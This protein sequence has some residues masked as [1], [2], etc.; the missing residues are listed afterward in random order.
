[1]PDYTAKYQ[2]PSPKPNES[3]DGPRGFQGLAQRVEDV[4]FTQFGK[5]NYGASAEIGFT[6]GSTASDPLLANLTGVRSGDWN[7]TGK[8]TAGTGVTA[9]VGDIIASAG[10]VVAGTTA[11]SVRWFRALATISGIAYE[12]RYQLSSLGDA[13][14]VAIKASTATNNF[15]VEQDGGLSHT[16]GSINRPIAFAMW[17]GGLSFSYTTDASMTKSINY[18]SGRFTVEPSVYLTLQNSSS[19]IVGALGSSDK[20]GVDI[21][22][23]Y[24]TGAAVTLT[25][26][27]QILAVQMTP[28]SGVGRKALAT[29][30]DSEM[31]TVLNVA[32]CRTQGCENEGIE[33][34]R[35]RPI[36]AEVWCGACGT[37]ITDVVEV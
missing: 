20:T 27:V 24:Y 16:S 2:F 36:G 19:F 32:T 5:V 11:G 10:H 4:L 28:T 8:V 31:S 6:G 26:S 1:M 15:Y 13:A 12:T 21:T 35:N 33:V 30:E 29:L 7:V 9:T 22:T 37:V 25:F 14:I 34:E 17:S 23:R 3:A 18:P